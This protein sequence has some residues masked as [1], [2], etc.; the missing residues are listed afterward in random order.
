M[1]TV[2]KAG[3]EGGAG[4]DCREE[5]EVPTGCEVTGWSIWSPCSQSCGSGL[6]VLTMIHNVINDIYYFLSLLSVST[7]LRQ[8]FIHFS[9]SAILNFL[10]L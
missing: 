1:E 6:K 2:E 9:L 4:S 7:K 10:D 3:C 5:E 8:F